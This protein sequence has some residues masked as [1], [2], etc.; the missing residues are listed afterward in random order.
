[1]CN[2]KHEFFLCCKVSLNTIQTTTNNRRRRQIIVVVSMFSA[3]KSIM[4]SWFVISFESNSSFSIAFVISFLFNNLSL[5]FCSITSTIVQSFFFDKKQFREKFE[6]IKIFFTKI[7]QI[8]D[9][10]IFSSE[11]RFKIFKLWKKI[12]MIFDVELFNAFH[13]F[14]DVR[15]MIHC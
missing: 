2:E 9:H 1:M 4:F 5:Y 10:C 13:N 6:T 11:T 14:H 7:F 12:R 8:F 3:K 15:E